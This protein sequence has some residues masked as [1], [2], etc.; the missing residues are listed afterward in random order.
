[1]F[2]KLLVL[3]IVALGRQRQVSLVYIVSSRIAWAIQG[4]SVAGKFYLSYL[5]WSSE[6]REPWL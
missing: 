5:N 2:K 3:G 6:W 4:D 1:M